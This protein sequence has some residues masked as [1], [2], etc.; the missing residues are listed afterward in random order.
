[1]FSQNI[2]TDRVSKTDT[3]FRNLPKKYMM[4][5]PLIYK[6]FKSQHCPTTDEDV[7]MK[8]VR[9]AWTSQSD[10]NQTELFHLSNWGSKNKNIKIHARVH[11]RMFTVRCEFFFLCKTR[12]PCDACCRTVNQS[13]T[14][15]SKL[16]A[17]RLAVMSPDGETLHTWTW[18]TW[19]HGLISLWKAL[20][21][22]LMSAC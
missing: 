1:M 2:W 14:F 9:W 17:L 21:S 12:T 11:L 8:H 15:S 7:M 4:I 6:S 18:T 10:S 20:L 3:Q 13:R 22:C 19:L 16:R 5:P